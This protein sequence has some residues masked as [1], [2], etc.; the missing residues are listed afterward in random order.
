MQI[1]ELSKQYAESKAKF[2]TEIARLEKEA[3]AKDEEISR[4]QLEVAWGRMVTEAIS[5]PA[6]KKF[7]SKMLSLA[8]R[9]EAEALEAE[10]IAGFKAAGD[11][12]PENRV[13]PDVYGKEAKRKNMHETTRESVVTLVDRECEKLGATVNVC[14]DYYQIFI[15]M[16]AA[17]FSA[18][19]KTLIRD[20]EISVECG[21]RKQWPSISEACHAI[22]NCLNLVAIGRMRFNESGRVV[23][24][25]PVGPP[26][27]KAMQKLIADKMQRNDPVIR[28][29]LQASCAVAEEDDGKKWPTGPH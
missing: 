25:K 12:C 29:A 19:V 14:P 27:E 16:D 26:P 11:T 8:D 7:T 15:D 13:A 6:K 1:E 5:E 20:Q 17:A 21:L 22:T 4:L 18:V 3:S 9:L 23:L 10:A 24:C 28:L 2:E